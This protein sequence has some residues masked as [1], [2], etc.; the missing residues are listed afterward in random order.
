MRSGRI[1]ALL[2]LAGVLAGSCR[3]KEPVQET[4]SVNPETIQASAS[5]DSYDVQVSSNAAWEASVEGGLSWITLTRTTGHENA[6]VGVRV[7]ENKYKDARE[8]GIVFKTA[9]GASARVLVRQEGA[10]GGEEA[11]DGRVLRIGTYNLRMSGLDKEAAYV[12]D[13]RKERLKQSLQDCNFDIFGLQEL[14]TTTQAWL[15]QELSSQYEFRYFSPYAQ[16]GVGDRA[17]GIGWRK[18]AFTMSDW[19]YFWAS[20]E[21]DV[22]SDND[23]G[24][25][26]DYKRGGCCCVLTHKASGMKLFFMNNH[27]CLNAEP[28]KAY[29]HVYADQEKRFNPDG[30]PSFF[31]GDMNARESSEEGSVYKTY[32]AWWKDPYMSL[33]ASKKSGAS[34]TYNG[35]SN[36]NGKSRIDY[37]FFRGEG[38]TPVQYR[39]DNKLYDGL[40]ASDHFPVWVEFAIK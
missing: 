28:N 15:D 22:M 13:V 19:H 5:L 25:Q 23:T 32:T 29:A 35:Y 38:I 21:P 3:E 24:S 8:A 11:P 17:Q 37:V 10:A 30:L 9:G 1:T 36:T 40:Y 31:V 7:G 14:S 27:G 12:W 26:G 34:G 20:G 33:D 6:K 39:C 4:I 2:L 16:R 18:D